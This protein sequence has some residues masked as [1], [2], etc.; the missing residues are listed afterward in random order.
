MTQ[1]SCWIGRASI[2]L[3]YNKYR[4][5]SIIFVLCNIIRV[6]SK[7]DLWMFVAI[8][9]GN[10]RKKTC[11]GRPNFKTNPCTASI[12]P[13][14][15][16]VLV[17]TESL[18]NILRGPIILTHTHVQDVSEP[19][20]KLFGTCSIHSWRCWLSFVFCLWLWAAWSCQESHQGN[21]T[22]QKTNI[23]W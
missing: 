13:Q 5:R 21:F 1:T 8:S 12:D 2:S 19:S 14:F 23:V 4:L 20:K 17:L 10:L 7:F 11:N 22:H 16:L 6:V 15:L 18:Q 9:M 3:K